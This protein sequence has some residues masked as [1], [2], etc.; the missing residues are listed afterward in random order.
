MQPSNGLFEQ[1]WT[2]N[3]K[4]GIGEARPIEEPGK[5][6]PSFSGIVYVGHVTPSDDDLPYTLPTKLYK[7]L[8]SYGAH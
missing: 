8:I 2:L 6:S 3:G 1:N 7:N 4:I 5:R